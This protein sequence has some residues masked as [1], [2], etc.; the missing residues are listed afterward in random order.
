[1]PIKAY[2]N[3]INTAANRLTKEVQ[4][5]GHHLMSKSADMKWRTELVTQTT[6]AALFWQKSKLKR[7]YT[8]KA[9]EGIAVKERTSSMM[10]GSRGGEPQVRSKEARSLLAYV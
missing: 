5:T 4:A 7:N 6:V 1:M 3:R 8:S 9:K 10:A 2:I